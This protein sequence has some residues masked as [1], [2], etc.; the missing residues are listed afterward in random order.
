MSIDLTHPKSDLENLPSCPH[1]AIASGS[2][3]PL[4]CLDALDLEGTSVMSASLIRL[5]VGKQRRARIAPKLGSDPNR[6]EVPS[7]CVWV[8]TAAHRTGGSL[9]FVCVKTEG[10]GV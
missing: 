2:G 1:P 10:L 5:T 6:A 8:K 4:S 7:A 3:S 9:P